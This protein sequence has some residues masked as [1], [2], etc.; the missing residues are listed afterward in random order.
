MENKHILNLQLETRNIVFGDSNSK[1]NEVIG[2][3]KSV[4]GEAVKN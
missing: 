1:K 4:I 3:L 2:Q